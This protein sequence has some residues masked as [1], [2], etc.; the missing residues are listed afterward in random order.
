MGGHNPEVRWQ[1]DW[2]GDGRFAHARSDI[3]DRVPRFDVQ[4]GSR[5][6][7]QRDEPTV[8]GATGSLLLDNDGGFF[9]GGDRALTAAQLAAPRR[10]RLTLDGGAWWLGSMHLAARRLGDTDL[11]R[12]GVLRSLTARAVTD[13]EYRYSAQGVTPAQAA[14]AVAAALGIA[15]DCRAGV[16]ITFGNIEHDGTALYFLRDLARATGGMTVETMAGGWR[17]L[18]VADTFAVAPPADWPGR[19]G[20]AFGPLDDADSVDLI[21][22]IRNSADIVGQSTQWQTQSGRVIVNSISVDVAARQRVWITIPRQR[23]ATERGTAGPT[24]TTDQVTKIARNPRGQVESDRVASLEGVRY[25][26]ARDYQAEVWNKSSQT[27][28]FSLSVTDTIDTLVAVP[29]S[30]PMSVPASIATNGKRTA[31]APPWFDSQFTGVP[32]V[33]GEWLRWAS[34]TPEVLEVTYPLRQ[35]TR[36][37]SALLRDRMVPGEKVVCEVGDE[38]YT[39]APVAVRLR[40]GTSEPTMLTAGVLLQHPVPAA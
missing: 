35:P 9:S 22:W 39:G 27:L 5:I 16:G 6:F 17:V 8:A 37:M 26:A 3:T 12:N 2:A 18:K 10:V 14:A 40:G 31:T 25:S 23:T 33:W 11:Y 13:P 20:R 28:T 32:A 30:R 4:A 36:A 1:V 29:A 24:F 19:F 7:A 38:T 34:V 21:E 15:I